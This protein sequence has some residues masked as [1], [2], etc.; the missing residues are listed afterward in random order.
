MSIA[1]AHKGD[2]GRK[3]RLDADQDI[4]AASV[5]QIKYVKPDGT[6]KGTWTAEVEDSQYAYY[7][8]QNATDLDQIGKWMIQLYI[9][10]GGAKIHGAIATFHVYKTTADY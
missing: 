8:T 3:F 10:M 6:T 2:V 5:V 7:I 1:R 4:S 9:E